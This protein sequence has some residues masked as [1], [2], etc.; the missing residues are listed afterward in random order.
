MGIRERV[1]WARGLSA[2][3]PPAGE[4]G[5]RAAPC[6]AGEDPRPGEG[7]FP[8]ATRRVP[9]EGCCSPPAV[10][11]DHAAAR[12]GT[13]KSPLPEILVRALGEPAPLPHRRPAARSN[14]SNPP[15]SPQGDGIAIR[16]THVVG[17]GNRG[18]VWRVPRRISYCSRAP[19][20]RVLLLW[21]LPSADTRQQPQ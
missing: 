17:A 20:F 4:A 7:A 6:P 11:P 15:A 12:S 1:L 16:W 18:D 19:A 21:L 13:V 8:G 3:T 9:R 2:G 10:R 14:C 5:T